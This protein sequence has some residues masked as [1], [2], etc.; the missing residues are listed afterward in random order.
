MR[1]L[2]P[3]TAILLFSVSYS[4]VLAEEKPV[5]Y[6]TIA[7]PLQRDLCDSGIQTEQ[8]YVG[9]ILTYI[10]RGDSPNTLDKE[11]VDKLNA[12]LLVNKRSGQVSTILNS[13]FNWDGKVTKEEAEEGARKSEFVTVDS[14]TE[15]GRQ[16]EFEFQVNRVM[17]HDL[18]KDGIVDYDEM[19]NTDNAKIP[20]PSRRMAALL[21]LAPDKKLLTSEDLAKEARKAFAVVDLNHDLVLT[22]KE[23]IPYREAIYRKTHGE[24]TEAP[25]GSEKH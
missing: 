18:N 20:E 24:L 4:Q 14:H 9:K 8:V 1:L 19:R 13:D 3:V 17:K 25:G 2:S 22:D 5:D 21:A 16:K 6:L 12:Y 7:W 10:Q 15:E 11:E 23:C